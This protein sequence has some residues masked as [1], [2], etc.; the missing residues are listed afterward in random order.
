[1]NQ[2]LEQHWTPEESLTQALAGLPL[3]GLRILEL[4]AGTGSMTRALLRSGVAH[5]ESWEIDPSLPAVDDPRVAWKIKDIARLSW[6]SLAG[7]TVAAIPP[8]EMLGHIVDALSKSCAKD[9][10]LM[11]PAR[12]LPMFLS[13]GFRVLS[14]IE[15]AAFDPPASGRHVL[16]AKGLLAY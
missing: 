15:G 16:V 7:L 3:A 14:V 5:I 11:I 13:L 6:E 1:M 8:Y 2:E 4:G 12:K 10:V 9:A